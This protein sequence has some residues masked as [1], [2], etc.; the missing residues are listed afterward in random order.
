[1][2]SQQLTDGQYSGG[3]SISVGPPPT[4][5]KDR[6]TLKSIEESDPKPPSIVISCEE[7]KY[8]QEEKREIN[9]ESEEEDCL[10]DGNGLMQSCSREQTSV[11]SK[12][13]SDAAE[14]DNDISSNDDSSEDLQ[15]TSLPRLPAILRK[16]SFVMHFKGLGKPS[17]VISKD[18]TI[19]DNKKRESLEYELKRIRMHE[20]LLLESRK[21]LFLRGIAF[22][23]NEEHS[24]FGTS[25]QV[26]GGQR[27]RTAERG[28]DQLTFAGK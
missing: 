5:I 15:R 11:S 24:S 1:M 16:L 28:G 14:S 19:G 4:T 8:D 20:E 12:R 17:K 25:Q 3:G 7:I 6:N 22:D 2:I 27:G 23:S 9:D 13:I 26:R 18:I 21:E 10:G